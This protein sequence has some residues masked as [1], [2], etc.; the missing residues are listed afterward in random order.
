MGLGPFLRG[1]IQPVCIM[2]HCLRF[3]CSGEISS[4]IHCLGMFMKSHMKKKKEKRKSK[5]ALGSNS[6]FVQ[7][8]LR[9]KRDGELLLLCCWSPAVASASKHFAELQQ[10][11]RQS[12]Y[13]VGCMD[14]SHR[15]R[16]G[17]FLAA[18]EQAQRM[19]WLILTFCDCFLGFCVCFRSPPLSTQTFHKKK[20]QQ[21]RRQ[22]INEKDSG[23]C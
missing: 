13:V 1:G 23:Q 22:S 3:S 6:S 19:S 20:K 14:A 21:G 11:S 7:Y 5:A 4:P 17:A 9:R 8:V 10:I 16:L 15:R 18:A 12:P 2:C